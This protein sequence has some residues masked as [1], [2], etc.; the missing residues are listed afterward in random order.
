MLLIILCKP[1][2]NMCRL[3]CTYIAQRQWQGIE[4]KNKIKYV[5][6]PLLACYINLFYHS[7]FS[8]YLMGP[9]VFLVADFILA[10]IFPTHYC[11]YCLLCNTPL[12]ALFYSFMKWRSACIVWGDSFSSLLYDTGLQ[13]STLL[14]SIILWLMI[15]WDIWI[16]TYH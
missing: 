5:E 15:V 11:L 9:A 10:V 7:F 1:E 2:Y 12:I 4:N 14:L 13:N 6:I 3:F 16:C 8:Q